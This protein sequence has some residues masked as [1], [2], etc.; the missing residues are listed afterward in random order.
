MSM[1]RVIGL[2]TLSLAAIALS[3]P[4]AAQDVTPGLAAQFKQICGTT[5]E[6][7]PPLPGDDIAATEAPG[8]FATDLK[9][10]SESRVVK[11]GE[12][13]AM[14]ALMPSSADPQHAAMLKCAVGASGA[15]FTEVTDAMGAMLSEKPRTG[16]TMQG[17]DY[18][19]FISGTSG[20]AVYS[21][22]D[23]WVSIYRMDILMRN[24]PA[25][26]LKKGAKPAP[27][28]SVR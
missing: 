4:G 23:G 11:V 9:R 2:L 24:I 3:G 25:K 5:A 6:A 14:R 1:H 27:A 13:F 7:G 8:F 17:F 21:E 16:K 18:A 19:Q 26:Y 28:P 10:A 20:F 12:R 22:P 15:S